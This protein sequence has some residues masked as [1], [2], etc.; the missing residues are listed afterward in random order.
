KKS[1]RR[2][3]A[4]RAS[5]VTCP[6]IRSPAAGHAHADVHDSR[7][8]EKHAQAERP[9]HVDELG[10]F[11]SCSRQVWSKHGQSSLPDGGE[12][13]ANSAVLQKRGG[14][15]AVNRRCS[16]FHVAPRAH[17][18][19]T[20]TTRPSAAPQPIADGKNTAAPSSWRRPVLT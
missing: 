19:M 17:A 5:R 7:R 2:S 12:N 14:Y 15:S 13:E 10:G 18:A 4:R 1:R 9:R 8:M 11:G 3:V 6:R 16:S 20:R